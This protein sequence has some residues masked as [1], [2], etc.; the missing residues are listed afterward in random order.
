MFAGLYMCAFE[1]LNFLHL[2]IS[3]SNI[4]F[5]DLVSVSED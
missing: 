2:F 1:C 3:L 5:S 4:S